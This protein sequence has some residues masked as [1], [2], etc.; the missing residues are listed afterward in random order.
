[1]LGARAHSVRHAARYDQRRPEPSAR[2]HR[3]P[4]DDLRRGR[5]RQR[6]HAGSDRALSVSRA[7]PGSSARSSRSPAS[8]GERTSVGIVAASAI[9]TR[10]RTR[11]AGSCI[12]SPPGVADQSDQKLSGLENQRIVIN[13]Q[14]MRLTTTAL[15]K[16]ERAEAYYRFPEGAKNFMQ[17][18]QLRAWARGRGNGWGQTGDLQFYVKIGPRRQQFLFLSH[19]GELRGRAG[20]V[21]ARSRRR[22]RSA[23]RAAAQAAERVSAEQQ[24]HALVH[25]R[26]LGADRAECAAG[27]ADLAALRGVRNGYMVYTVDPGVSA[28]NLRAMQELAVGIVRVDSSGARRDAHHARRHTRSVGRRHPPREQ[29][30]HAR[31]RGAGGARSRYRSRIV[32][33]ELLAPRREFPP[34]RRS[35]VECRRRRH[36]AEH[37]RAARAVLRVRSSDMS[38]PVTV[39]HYDDRRARRSI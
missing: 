23:Q 29:R 5:A 26:R 18:R 39:T 21:A 6:V 27:R 28:P 11:R 15:A 13:E 32:P 31:I 33:R 22:F 2:A 30:Q 34:A 7:R 19:A 38:M 16:Y 10:T 17:Y 8:A 12:E 20:R 25:R 9:G 35:G 24:R 1:M 3:A 37:D 36:R 14:S 4:D